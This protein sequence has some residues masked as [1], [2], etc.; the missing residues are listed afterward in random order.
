[1]TTTAN[2][3]TAHT[4]LTTVRAADGWYNATKRNVARW[5]TEELRAVAAEITVPA[6][7]ASALPTYRAATREECLERLCGWA[8]SERIREWGVART[9]ARQAAAAEFPA[10]LAELGAAL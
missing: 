1:M 5:C 2:D 6:H 4:I 10:A 7:F 3:I 9:A 8:S